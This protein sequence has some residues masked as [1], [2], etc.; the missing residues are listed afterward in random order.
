MF[1][2]FT[3][4]LMKAVSCEEGNQQYSRDFS[5]LQ[6]SKEA[7]VIVEKLVRWVL[8]AL[9]VDGVTPALIGYLSLK[10]F[11]FACCLLYMQSFL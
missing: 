9:C 2:G 5:A 7:C 1:T 10:F 3:E 4:I 11:F 8:A 6:E